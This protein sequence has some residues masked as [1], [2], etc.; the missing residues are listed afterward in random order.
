MSTKL[1]IGIALLVLAAGLAP[2]QE[3]AGGRR[4]VMVSSGGL[5]AAGAA[6][7]GALGQ[8]YREIDDPNLGDR[9]LLVR[10][11]QFPG[12]PGRMVRVGLAGGG[13]AAAPAA[14]AALPVIRPG[15]RVIVEEHTAVVDAVLEAR[16]LTPAAVGAVFEV[17]L[18]IGGRVVRV[19]ALGSGRA[20]FATEARP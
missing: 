5:L 1:A 19:V 7:L 11:E 18:V 13:Q 14:V 17:R 8:L 15:D 9:W 2:A 3:A 20:A 4:Q 12:G 6:Q 16:A 10:N